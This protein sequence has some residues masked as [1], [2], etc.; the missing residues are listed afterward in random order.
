[1]EIRDAAEGAWGEQAGRIASAPVWIRC[2]TWLALVKLARAVDW[3]FLETRVG[4]IY[5]GKPGVRRRRRR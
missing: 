4:A 2:S 1:L 3:S 5:S